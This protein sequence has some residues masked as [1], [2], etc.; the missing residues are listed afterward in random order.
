MI[1]KPRP[2][3]KLVR[4]SREG[5]RESILAEYQLDLG[6]CDDSETQAT[7][8]ARKVFKGG[9]SRV[10]FDDLLPLLESDLMTPRP[11]PREKLVRFSRAG[12]RDR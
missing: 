5:F 3:E 10:D 12:S 11:R 8:K 4:F 9:V 1:P 6:Q 7:R 2:R